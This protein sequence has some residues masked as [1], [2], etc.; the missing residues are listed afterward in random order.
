[1][2]QQGQSMGRAMSGD[3]IMSTPD[4]IQ[5]SYLGIAAYYKPAM[6]LSILRDYILGKER[7]DYAFRTYIERWAF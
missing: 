2:K 5:S 3:P 7:F 1:M 4:V 6:G